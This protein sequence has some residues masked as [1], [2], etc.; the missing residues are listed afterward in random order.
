MRTNTPMTLYNRYID[1]ETRSEAYQRTALS[2]V[3]WENSKA[4]NVRATGGTMA[5]NQAT[6][7]IPKALG[8]NYLLPKAWALAIVDEEYEDDK[9]TL[10]PGDFVVKGTVAEEITSEFS[11]SALQAKYDNVLAITSV[12]TMDYGSLSLQHWEV[13]AK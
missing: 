11:I 1:P 10:Q 7:F 4:A 12:D 9:W 8:A 2:A 13:G 5:A 6:I 3:Q